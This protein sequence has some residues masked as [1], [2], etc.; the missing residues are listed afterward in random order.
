MMEDEKDKKI[1][2]LES[3]IEQLREELKEALKERD[4]FE[5]A[6]ADLNRTEDF[7][8]FAISCPNCSG[9]IEQYQKMRTAFERRKRDQNAI[10]A[11][12]KI[13]NWSV[14]GKPLTLTRLIKLG[15]SAEN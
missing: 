7:D 13:N 4:H 10:S 9:H 3:T 5:N 2:S 15:Y 6:Y 1:V 14:N 11:A 8:P 12:L